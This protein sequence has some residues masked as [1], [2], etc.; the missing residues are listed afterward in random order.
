MVDEAK[1]EDLVRICVLVYVPDASSLAEDDQ[2][3]STE[4]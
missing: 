3:N 1:Q 4:E 2:C